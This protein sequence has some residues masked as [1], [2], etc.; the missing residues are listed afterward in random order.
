MSPVGR[1]DI[2]RIYEVVRPRIRLTPVLHTSGAD[3]GLVDFPL[4]L[5]LEYLQYAG[6]FKTRGAFAHLLTRD[7]PDA[8]VVAASGGNHGVAVAYAASKMGVAASIFVPHV[9]S[10]A[11]IARIEAYGANLRIVGERYSDALLASE[12]WAKTSGAMAIHAFDQIETLLGQGTLALELSAQ[13]PEIDTVLVSVGGGGLIAGLAAWYAGSVRVIGVEPEKAPTLTRAL[14]AGGPVDAPAG[15]IAADSLAPARIGE[16]VYPIAKAYVE[17]VFVVPDE[18][19]VR[20][21]KLLWDFARIV[22]EPGG[23]AAFA[24][25]LSGAYRPKPTEHVAVILSGGN[26]TAL[27]DP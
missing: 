12:E 13:A 16:L 22:T 3:F 6:S 18:E 25:L 20:S 23:A 14:A 17:D 5:K 11:K 1:D 7:I 4:T 15:G 19:I 27:P 8:G 24:A 10:P 26:T 9:S 2:A 21:Q